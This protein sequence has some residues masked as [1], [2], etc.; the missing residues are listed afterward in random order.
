MPDLTS[1]EALAVFQ[2]W[3]CPK[4]LGPVTR[5]GAAPGERCSFCLALEDAEGE[6]PESLEAATDVLRGLEAP[7]A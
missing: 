5:P 4:C 2:P 7:G 1:T 3:R 6:S